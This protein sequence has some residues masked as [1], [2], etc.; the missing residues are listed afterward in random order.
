MVKT[1]Q[2]RLWKGSVTKHICILGASK[3]K[4]CVDVPVM[5][6]IR[7]VIVWSDICFTTSA[8]WVPH[9]VNFLPFHVHFWHILSL[10]FWVPH[11]EWTTASC[12]THDVQKQFII[13]EWF[14]SVASARCT[15]S[16]CFL[17]SCRGLLEQVNDVKHV[18]EQLREWLLWISNSL[19]SHYVRSLERMRR[20]SGRREAGNAIGL[21]KHRH[22]PNESCLIRCAAK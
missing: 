10:L 12:S 8:W 11:M 18:W 16:A 1:L 22:L 7:K 15:N 3:P 4:S 17:H 19:H 13:T 20:A 2:G 6:S 21:T 9:K 5:L 14:R